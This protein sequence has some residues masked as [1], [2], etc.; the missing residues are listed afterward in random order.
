MTTFEQYLAHIVDNGITIREP[1]FTALHDI[2]ATQRKKEYFTM[3]DVILN[4]AKRLG[5]VAVYMHFKK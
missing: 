1:Y 4:K 2:V 3:K 5:L